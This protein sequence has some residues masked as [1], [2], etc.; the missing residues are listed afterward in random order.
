[1][2]AGLGLERLRGRRASPLTS[3]CVVSEARSPAGGRL[4]VV[5]I[6]GGVAALETALGLHAVARGR[7]DVELVTPESDF[8]YRPLAVAEPFGLGR[9]H[10]F[11]LGLVASACGALLTL[12]TAQ[13]V[14]PDRHVVTTASGDE[15]PYDVLVVATGAQPV[16]ALEPALTF[17]GPADSEAFR[18]LLEEARAGGPG[19]LVFAVPR[20]AR[21]GRSHSTNLPS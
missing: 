15:L 9:V 6:G 16:R 13:T 18:R 19:E 8:W 5:V 1:M 10:H 21:R 4:R 2:G 17:R 11:D 14:D 20:P 12:A 7:V 3:R